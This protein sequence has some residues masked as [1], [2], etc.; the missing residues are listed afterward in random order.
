MVFF[1]FFQINKISTKNLR[2]IKHRV[3]I[4]KHSYKLYP[5]TFLMH[6]WFFAV[7]FC[8]LCVH[9][10]H[11]SY[12]V[13]QL[14]GHINIFKLILSKYKCPMCIF[15]CRWICI[16][17]RARLVWPG[18]AWPGLCQILKCT[19]LLT[20]C[21]RCRCF[22]FNASSFCNETYHSYVQFKWV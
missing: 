20:G 17:T 21:K 3:R 11:T 6:I 5:F 19:F 13:Y 2:W 10:T 14:K 9:F 1:C 7:N 12:R 18:L 4:L 15:L 8:I 16:Y 22:C